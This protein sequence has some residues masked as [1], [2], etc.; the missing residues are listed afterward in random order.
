MYA[1]EFSKNGRVKSVSP[2]IQDSVV[3]G[4]ADQ[5]FFSEF[6]KIARDEAAATERFEQLERLRALV[7]A[8]G[9]MFFELL[10]SQAA[11]RRVFSIALSDTNDRE[12]LDV[13]E[14]GVCSDIFTDRRLG[15]RNLQ[16]EHRS[17]Y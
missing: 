11:E 9:G 6:D 7:R 8:L 3:R 13:L 17:I 5:L 4:Q 14:L 15:R 12:V 1:E 2:T 10:I 16:A